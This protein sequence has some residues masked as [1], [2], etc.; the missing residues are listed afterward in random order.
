[1]EPRQAFLVGDYLFDLLSARAAGAIA[2]LLVNHERAREFAEHADYCI[3]NIAE[4][5][6]IVA[7]HNSG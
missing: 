1:M 2:V 6:D 5:L 3:E 7:N 4:I